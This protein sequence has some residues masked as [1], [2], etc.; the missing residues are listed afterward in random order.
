MWRR[1]PTSIS[2]DLDTRG[3]LTGLRL[4][5]WSLS[6]FWQW[7]GDTIDVAEPIVDEESWNLFLAVENLFAEYSGGHLTPDQAQVALSLL[8][9]PQEVVGTVLSR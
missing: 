3:H 9:A 6:E 8:G 2:P 1:E 7:F 5:T 4:G